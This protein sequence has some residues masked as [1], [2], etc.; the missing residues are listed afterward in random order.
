[1]KLTLDAGLFVSRFRESDLKHSEAVAFFRRC[2]LDGVR[3]FAPA[4][5]LAE[6][7]GALSRLHG[8]PRFGEIAVMRILAQERL[9]LRE[10]NLAFAEKAARLAARHSL[11]GADATYLNV[12]I[13]TRST[14]VTNDAE[15][16]QARSRAR[17]ITPGEWL[18]SHR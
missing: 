10:I 12:A 11:K 4:L 6:V 14:L 1:M 15:L 13:E 2:D 9:D 7:A 16:L 17:V 3:L 8:A 5:V 18:A